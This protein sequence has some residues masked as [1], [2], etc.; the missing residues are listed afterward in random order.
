MSKVKA[1]I[2]NILKGRFLIHESSLQNWRMI[3]FIV[4][5][6]LI[7]ISSAHSSDRKVLLIS[8]LNQL[9]RELRTTYIDTQTTLLRMRMESNIIEKARKMGLHPSQIPPER[10]K[11]IVSK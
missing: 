10:I 9:K 5:L 1:S 11:V 6:L 3:L 2:Y 4:T 7:I 8:E